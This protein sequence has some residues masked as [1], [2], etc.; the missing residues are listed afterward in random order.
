MTLAAPSRF[1]RMIILGSLALGA[2]ALPACA[3]DS[4][5]PDSDE[6]VGADENID[7]T[8]GAISG[9][10]KVGATLI[11]TANVN[12]RTGPSTSK[13]I[14][15][16]VA[17]G[18]KVTVVSGTPQNGFYKVKHNGTVGWSYGQYYKKAGAGSDYRIPFACGE[19]RTV[20]N[21]NHTSSH[22]GK[23]EYA[24]DFAVPM[25]TSVRAMRSG[26]VL[27]VRKVSSPGSSCFN[28]GGS[29]CA[30]LANT[31]EVLHDN[32]TVGLYMHLSSIGVSV[33]QSIQ[34]GQVLGKSGASGWATGPH[35]HVQ[36]QENCGIW[37]CQSKPFTF[38]E[39]ST[40]PS[41][42]T[43]TSKNNCQ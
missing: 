42:S 39:D 41:G 7:R 16:V 17:N 25:G 2:A 37:W 22:D 20:S 8:E 11:A 4:G 38:V 13:S 36:V 1:A 5:D 33:N 31:V 35:L 24:F 14:L 9:S 43:V 27:R 21:G 32:G 18:S 30:N 26:K 40:L 29:A 34:Q 28:G 15:H 19:K 12:L 6:L 10:I 23:D 3:V